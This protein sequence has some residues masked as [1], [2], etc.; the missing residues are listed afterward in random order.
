MKDQLGRDVHLHQLPRRIVSLVPSQTELLYSLGLEEEVV[1][2]TK[3]CIHPA[4]WFRS[5]QRVGGTK[6]IHR[7]KIDSLQ[8]DLILANKEEN[9]QA[10]VEDL[11]NDYPVWISDIH[12]LSDALQMIE[13]VGTLCGRRTESVQLAGQIRHAAQHHGIRPSSKKVL[14]LIWY[15][16]WMAAGRDTFIDSMIGAA[17]FRQSVD[18]PRYP[19][20]SEEEMVALQPDIVFLSSEPFPFRDKHVAE[21]QK[22]LPQAHIHL[23]DGELFSWYGSRLLHSFNYFRILNEEL[24]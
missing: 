4:H 5:K 22:V 16:P 8:P 17:G 20:L 10:Q 23:V 21:L 7:S 14:Y 1:G 24:A 13:C 2:I 18:T 6:Q 12:D 19:V 15:Q 3:F 11:A 9:V